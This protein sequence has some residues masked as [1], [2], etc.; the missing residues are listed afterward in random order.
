M[1]NPA[2]DSGNCV[3]LFVKAPTP[4]RVKTRLCPPLSH[5]QAAE[6]YQSFT[7]DTIDR[8]NENPFHC[9]IAYDPNEEFPTPAW[10]GFDL[11]WFPQVGA[12]LGERL[13]HA[14]QTAFDR[15]FSRILALGTDSPG[16]GIDQISQAFDQLASADVVMGPALDGGYYLIGLAKPCPALFE[17]IAWSSP[18]V[19]R[20][21]RERVKQHKL[22]LA[23]IASFHDVDTYLDLKNLHERFSD[24]KIGSSWKR[25]STVLNRL[26]EGKD[27]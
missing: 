21:T 17:H 5:E 3:V 16:F 10:T 26:F 25:T 7:K 18:E 12:D 14:F 15:E 4:G 8:L 1:V 23:E 24:K 2:V 6:L 27:G 19:A 11:P 9:L 22:S 13:Q 20:Q